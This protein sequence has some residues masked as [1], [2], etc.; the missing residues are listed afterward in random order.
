[1]HLRNYES[2]DISHPQCSASTYARQVLETTAHAQWH[3]ACTAKEH[4][5]HSA[6]RLLSGPAP[7]PPPLP[8]GRCFFV[9]PRPGG[10]RPGLLLRAERFRQT[11]GVKA[12]APGLSDALVRAWR[13]VRSV[14]VVTGAGVSAESGIRTYRGR[15]GIYD[16]PVEG[17]RTVEAVS[18]HTLRSDPD[19][20]W[21]AIGRMAASVGGAEP[22]AAHHAI[23][24]IERA[25]E[26]F[27]LLTQN[28]DGLHQR[29]GSRNV[30]DIHGTVFE[31]SC[32]ACGA[33]ARMGEELAEVRRA[34]KC[35]DCGGVMR[36]DVVLF[37]EM[38]PE[39]KV[40]EMFRQIHGDPPDAVVIAGTTAVFPYIAAPV[41]TAL[42]HGKLTIEVNPEPTH[43]SDS[44]DHSLRGPA[45]KLLPEL[46]DLLERA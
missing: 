14:V 33:R 8:P 46:A 16:D 45:G 41:E 26:R 30:I 38:L 34:P 11:A 6:H 22:N 31:T 23:A 35:R 36:P 7:P 37:G 28:V 21:A 19:R 40:R 42:A 5:A 1:M 3:A 10:A 15:G 12:P 13:R 18:G 4:R 17:E 39:H 20:T 29:A 43:L 44:V 27:V 24:R 32:M 2:H 25:M 9:R